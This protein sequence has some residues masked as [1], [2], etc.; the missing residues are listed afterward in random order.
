MIIGVLARTTRR[1]TYYG[2]II[3]K[4]ALRVLAHIVAAAAIGGASLAA[5]HA[6]AQDTER[7][8]QA[9]RTAISQTP[10][11]GQGCFNASYPLLVWH[12]VACANPSKSKFSQ[13]PGGSGPAGGYN[14]YAAVSKGLT[15]SALGSFPV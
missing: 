3:M 5:A 7:L 12:Q 9:W 8:Q 6:A 1:H 11:P 14:D 15:S 13:T 4:S 2:G 10:V